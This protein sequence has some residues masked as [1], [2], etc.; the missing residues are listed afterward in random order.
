MQTKGFK[1]YFPVRMHSQTYLQTFQKLKLLKCQEIKYIWTNI[2]RT[3]KAKKFEFYCLD[4]LFSII[5]FLLNPC[6]QI[7]FI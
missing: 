5:Y 1:F 7:N 6:G 2:P 3:F 4:L